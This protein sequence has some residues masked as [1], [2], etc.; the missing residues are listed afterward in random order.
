MADLW[1]FIICFALL[2]ILGCS[3]TKRTPRAMHDLQWNVDQE[4]R[5]QLEE[6][7]K[8]GRLPQK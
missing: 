8:D 2:C 1:T 4:H 5:A 6:Y 7:R 3:T